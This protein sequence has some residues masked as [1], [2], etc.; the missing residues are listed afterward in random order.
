MLATSQGIERADLLSIMHI[1]KALDC[2]SKVK[3]Q[4]GKFVLRDKENDIHL[5]SLIGL[6]IK[7]KTRRSW[8]L[9]IKFK[10]IKIEYS[11]LFFDL[12]Y[13]WL[14]KPIKSLDFLYFVFIFK[15]GG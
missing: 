6:V 5:R 7:V 2:L 3:D 14:D 8:V 12:S 10:M 13:I 9:G 11:Y 1:E 4:S 15:K